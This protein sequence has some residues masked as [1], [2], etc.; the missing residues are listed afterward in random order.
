MLDCLEWWSLQ[1]SAVTLP[2][3]SLHSHLGANKL[4]LRLS[5]K[6]MLGMLRNEGG[7]VVLVKIAE[8]CHFHIYFNNKW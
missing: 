7:S 3:S 1:T 5:V 2:I 4:A 6:T 8:F